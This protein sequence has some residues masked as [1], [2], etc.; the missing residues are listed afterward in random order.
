[1]AGIRDARSLIMSA[2]AAIRASVA[3][4]ARGQKS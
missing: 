4:N 2:D 3:L 1:M